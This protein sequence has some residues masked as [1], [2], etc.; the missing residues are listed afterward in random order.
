MGVAAEPLCET[1][2][3]R[4]L[5]VWSAL[6]ELFLDQELEPSDY[7]R[8]AEVIV[9]SGYSPAQAEAMLR[10]EVAP[11]FVVNLWSVAGE[12]EAWP[13]K[14]VRER[15]LEKRGSTFTRVATRLFNNDLLS[16]EWAK[17]AAHINT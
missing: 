2:I 5:P 7:R 11:A 14:Y 1:E 13:E 15:V 17:V 8:I 6:S 4:R 12:W 10:C 3:A 16:R 9:R